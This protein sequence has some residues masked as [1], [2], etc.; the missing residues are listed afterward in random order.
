MD[1][2]EKCGF[3]L[4]AAEYYSAVFKSKKKHWESF[5]SGSKASP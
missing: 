5:T 1:E 4:P 3:V 2:K